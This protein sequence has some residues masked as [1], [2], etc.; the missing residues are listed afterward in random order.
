MAILGL[1]ALGAAYHYGLLNI[2]GTTSQ[3]QAKIENEI[4]FDL[5][6]KNNAISPAA[7][8]PIIKKTTTEK[9]PVFSTKRIIIETQE[10]L[11][12]TGYK[13]NQTGLLDEPTLQAIA[14]YQNDNDLP[15][16]GNLTEE[17]YNHLLHKRAAKEDRDWSRA[18]TKET[19]YSHNLYLEKWPE[20][21]HREEAH[22]FIS[23]MRQV[24]IFRKAR[25]ERTISAYREYLAK[26]PTGYRIEFFIQRLAEREE[27]DWLAAK[28]MHMEAAYQTYLENWPT[29]L[30]AEESQNNIAITRDDA[31]FKE[32]IIKNNKAAFIQYK[33][34]FPE[35]S[36]LEEADGNLT[37][38]E[39]EEEKRPLE[40]QRLEEKRQNIILIKDELKRLGYE[41]I[42]LL[43]HQIND[44]FTAALKHF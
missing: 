36:H 16:E 13:I 19:I 21:S 20:G 30:H 32:A 24:L 7:Q 6:Q 25:K 27:A 18:I 29:G 43:D 34:N 35:G 14:K 38:L 41:N 28:D 12:L 2:D 37:R 3:S 33:D 31:A 8:K 11:N 22:K 9:P 23:M 15:L 4:N 5:G 10:S 40:Q 39:I 17:F 1:G 42:S 26:Y 44:D